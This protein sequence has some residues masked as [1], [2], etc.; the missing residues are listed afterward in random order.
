MSVPNFSHTHFQPMPDLTAEQLDALEADIRARGVLVPIVV[1]QHGR[2]I[3]G[4]N[5]AAIAAKL[6][7]DCPREVREV[8]DDD[9]AHDLALTL[10]CARRHLTSEQKRTLIAAELERRP[11]DSNRAIARRVGC[12]HK[13]VAAVRRGGEIPQASTTVD[14]EFIDKAVTSIRASAPGLREQMIVGCTV[15]LLSG[16]DFPTVQEHVVQGYRR[17][18]EHWAA[19]GP[20]VEATWTVEVYGE[21]MAVLLGEGPEIAAQVAEAGP[22]LELKPGGRELWLDVLS[23]VPTWLAQERFEKAG[24]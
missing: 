12:D 13:T 23:G 20:V 14:Q 18:L 2:I 1:D 7:I 8:A 3:D 6:G 9:E 24:Q 19:L 5:R 15:L 10:N 11:Q 4:N 21:V 17:D 16:C 22:Q